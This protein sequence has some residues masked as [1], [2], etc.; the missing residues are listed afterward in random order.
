VPQNIQQNCENIPSIVG[1]DSSVGIV[2]GYG[3][4]GP[5]IEF[6]LGRVFSHLSRPAL[7]SI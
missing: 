1:R 4:D 7:V 2:T 5:G 3:L 6:R